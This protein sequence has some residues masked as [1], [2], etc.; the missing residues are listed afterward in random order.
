MKHTPA[1]I[2]QYEREVDLGA[3]AGRAYDDFIKEF[4]EEK[5]EILFDNFRALPLTD[6][7]SLMEVKRMSYALDT[8]ENEIKTVIETGRLAGISLSEESENE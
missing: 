3:R 2:E 1:E 4:V 6:E 5:R 7:T 8:L